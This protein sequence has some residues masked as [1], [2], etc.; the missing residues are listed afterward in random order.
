[1]GLYGL[2]MQQQQQQQQSGMGLHFGNL[3][4]APGKSQSLDFNPQLQQ[5]MPDVYYQHLSSSPHLYSI[6]GSPAST[7]CHMP[8]SSPSRPHFSMPKSSNQS[9]AGNK[10]PDIILTGVVTLLTSV[11][12]VFHLVI[13]N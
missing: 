1:M 5:L 11:L 12:I 8:A 7:L 10:I 3:P 4:S 13:L 6:Q 9:K 2:L